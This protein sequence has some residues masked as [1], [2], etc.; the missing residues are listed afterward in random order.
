M[1]PPLLP[2]LFILVA[3]AAAEL[4]VGPVSLSDGQHIIA[5]DEGPSPENSLIRCPYDLQEGQQVVAVIWELLQDGK[6]A[7]SFKWRPGRGGTTTGILRGKVNA[8]REDS[9][10]ELTSVE[11]DLA[12]LYSCTVKTADGERGN[13]KADILVQ[14]SEH[15]L[16]ASASAAAADYSMTD[17][18]VKAILIGERG[19]MSYEE[20][21][22]PTNSVVR[23][24]VQLE[25][26]QE[27]ATVVWRVQ[28][29]GR[30]L[31]SFK[32]KASGPKTAYG[33]LRGKVNLDRQDSDLELTSLKY[34]MAGNY[35]CSVSLTDG[36]K[37]AA[38]DEVLIVDTTGNEHSIDVQEDEQACT[39]TVT[40]STYAYPEPTIRSGMYSDQVGGFYQTFNNWEVVK[41]KN[42]SATY[43]FRD[44][45]IYVDSNTPSDAT[46]RT[47]V[48]VMK[49]NGDLVPITSFNRIYVPKFERSCRD[50]ELEPNQAVAYN[51]YQRT[52]FG[53]IRKP[54]SGLLEAEVTC[55]E[56]YVPR[57]H[58]PSVTMVCQ[59]RGGN[60]YEWLHGEQGYVPQHLI[61]VVP[62]ST[63]EPPATTTTESFQR[64]QEHGYEYGYEYMPPESEY[65]EGDDYEE[66]EEEEDYPGEEEDYGNEEDYRYDPYEPYP[67]ATEAPEEDP[68]TAYDATEYEE[69]EPEPAPEDEQAASTHEE[70]LDCGSDIIMEVQS[71]GRALLPSPAAAAALALLLCLRR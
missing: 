24:P 48:S 1:E 59:H 23:C 25:E 18:V 43:S 68:S 41:H 10:L 62:P 70:C 66:E 5:Y 60:D 55:A 54:D 15:Q 7:G 34:N 4:A 9:D 27:V 17:S 65:E 19:Y 14:G 35:S 16:D 63:T 58:I 40:E 28:K 13:A 46:Y 26:G 22:S 47:E 56:G 20:G 53:G 29:R 50:L 49:A 11:Y 67:E 21:P 32:W 64:R 51:S 3:G 6:R 12:G 39:L 33:L 31:G 30:R 69:P 45:K 2:L 36:K 57:D 71:G 42:G 52:C 61:C 37:G 44:H 38:D 8:R